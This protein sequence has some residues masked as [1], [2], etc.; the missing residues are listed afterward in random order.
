[1]ENKIEI[2]SNEEFGTV[3]TITEGDRILFC[4]KD[5]AVAL[6]YA[7]PRKAVKDHCKGV[8]KRD[9][10]TEGG[11][12]SLSY[13]PEGDVY[14][15][16]VG[17]KLPSAQ[18]FEVWLFETVVP[19][20]RRHGAYITTPLL[21]KVTENPELLEKIIFLMFSE[22]ERADQLSARLSDVQPKADYYD[23]FVN[24]SDCTNI[25]DTAKELAVPERQFCQFLQ[26]ER[27]LFRCPAGNLMP[28]SKKSNEGLFIVRDYYRHGHFG[29]YTLI[30]PAG[31]NLLRRMLD[32]AAM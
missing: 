25:R 7:N 18:R 26:N 14:R 20:I 24:P 29:T 11:I 16:I 28:Y 13:M 32:L 22:R 15:L 2:F 10:L 27:F 6:G 19:S 3:R 17:S 12:Q 30:T 31:K 9:T 21:Q 4:A 5:V 23:A 8:T 1:M